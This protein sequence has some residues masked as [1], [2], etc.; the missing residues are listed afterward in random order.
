MVKSP[1][2]QF[3]RQVIPGRSNPTDWKLDE[4]EAGPMGKRQDKPLDPAFRTMYTFSDEFGLL[5]GGGAAGATTRTFIT[6][7]DSPAVTELILSRDHAAEIK[8][9]PQGN[10]EIELIQMP[11]RGPFQAKLTAEEIASLPRVAI[12]FERRDNVR[13][14]DQVA[15][16]PKAKRDRD[17]GEAGVRQV[18]TLRISVGDWSKIVHVPYMEYPA[19]RFARWGEIEPVALPGANQPLQIALSTTL[20]PMPAQVTLEK[21]EL[22]PYPGG[23]KMSGLMRDFRAT[24]RVV[25]FDSGEES[26]DVAHMNHPVYF[27]RKRPL[28][29]P[30]ESWLFFQRGWNPQAGENLS[31][32]GVGNR[33][34]VGTMTLGSIMIGVGLL[35]AFYVKPIIV[36]RMKRKALAAAA[37]TGTT[38]G[39]SAEHKKPKTSREAVEV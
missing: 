26:V 17:E 10:G 9:F 4:P 35:Y 23:D 25:D 2:M 11:P 16:V 27:E 38:N 19:E 5:T 8:P 31:I 34:G 13:R 18:V 7:A 6:S 20:L 12:G 28:L 33:P 3:R 32:L 30:N 22:V 39:D 21:F 36:G 14:V 24:L 15:D 37:A 29:F 1:T